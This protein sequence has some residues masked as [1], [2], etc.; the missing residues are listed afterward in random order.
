MVPWSHMTPRKMRDMSVGFAPQCFH[1]GRLSHFLK[2]GTFQMK[3][4]RLWE[5]MS[6]LLLILIIALARILHDEPL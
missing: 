5:T 3:P 2:N 6:N 1:G 4:P